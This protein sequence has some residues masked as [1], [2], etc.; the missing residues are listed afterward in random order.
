MSAY[1]IY[2]HIRDGCL[3]T[4]RSRRRTSS[5]SK[6]AVCFAFVGLQLRLRHV[7]R[8]RV[9]IHSPFFSE[10]NLAFSHPVYLSAE[11]TTERDRSC[12]R[13]LMGAP[14]LVVNACLF[15]VL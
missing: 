6:R 5:P 12:A 11:L 8:R 15:L 2:V 7:P 4:R 9:L 13:R 1:I 14:G 10:P 3:T